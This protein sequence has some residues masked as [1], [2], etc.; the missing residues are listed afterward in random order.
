MLRFQ[1]DTTLDEMEGVFRQFQLAKV[2]PPIRR[3]AGL[4]LAL[5]V[6]VA[7]PPVGPLRDFLS[8][9]LKAFLLALLLVGTLFLIL[10]VLVAWL[11][12]RRLVRPLR[13]PPASLRAVWIPVTV[14][15]DDAGL[16]VNFLDDGQPRPWSAVN[17]FLETRDHAIIRFRGQDFAF[18]PKRHLTP[19]G[20]EDLRNLV[21]ARQAAIAS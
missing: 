16:S 17:G 6:V 4:I 19:A 3:L 1:Y 11:G 5:G 9:E 15:I 13:A 8:G 2:G 12:L 14:Q 21:V 10:S 18:V 20:L 7:I